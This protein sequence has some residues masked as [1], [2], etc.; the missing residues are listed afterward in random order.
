MDYD[1]LS[2]AR[3]LS[4]GLTT[5]NLTVVY[6]FPLLLVGL[7]LPKLPFNFKCPLNALVI[8]KLLIFYFPFINN[9]IVWSEDWKEKLWLS[10]QKL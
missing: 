2:A 6:Q 9:F 8:K 3:D 1:E 10:H 4:E 7:Q 5:G